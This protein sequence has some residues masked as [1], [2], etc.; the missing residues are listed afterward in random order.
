[1]NTLL[2]QEIIQ[3]A[4]SSNLGIFSLMILVLGVVAFA[5]FRKAPAWVQ[6]T[7]FIPLFL[8]VAGFGYSIFGVDSTPREHVAEPSSSDTKEV[9]DP[10]LSEVLK[11]VA[12][13]EKTFKQ[14]N[15]SIT[16]ITGAGRGNETDAILS[17]T[18]I[19]KI[20]SHVF[21]LDNKGNDRE[22]GGIDTYILKKS[23]DIGP[24]REAI[25][26][27]NPQKGKDILDDWYVTSFSVVDK[28]REQIFDKTANKWLGDGKKSSLT[29]KLEFNK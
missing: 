11:P 17:V 15:V 18:L 2:N 23:P 27:I 3:A 19:G 16:H 9:T 29:Y 4:S 25:F 1:M 7:A 28:N 6:L 8:G 20:G 24:V 5:F 10:V 26:L 22:S 13:T 12:P 21:I 14:T